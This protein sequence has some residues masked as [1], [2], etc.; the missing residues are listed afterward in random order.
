MKSSFQD[1]TNRNLAGQRTSAWRF[2]RRRLG[3]KARHGVAWLTG[4]KVARSGK[5][6]NLDDLA[7]PG[8]R[9]GALS[10]CAL[11][12]LIGGAGA[13]AALIAGWM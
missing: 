1:P 7:N 8:V 13:G 4:R 11:V 3:A 12:I 2:V 5:A 10:G 6:L 9:P